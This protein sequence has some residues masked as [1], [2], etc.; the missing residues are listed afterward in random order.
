MSFCLCFCGGTQIDNKEYVATRLW[1]LNVKQD[2]IYITMATLVRSFAPT[3][4]SV[5]QNFFKDF[6]IEF[7]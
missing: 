5:L 3:F 1:Q 2:K 6:W 7:Y 4:P